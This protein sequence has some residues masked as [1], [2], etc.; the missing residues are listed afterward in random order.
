M[1]DHSTP[2]GLSFRRKIGQAVRITAPDGA[3]ILVWVTYTRDRSAQVTTYAPP[4]YRI[5]RAETTP[6][7][8]GRTTPP[9]TPART[10]DDAAHTRAGLWPTPLAL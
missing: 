8:P 5:T 7:A 10:P 1:I 9:E 4:E 3:E 2:N 6:P